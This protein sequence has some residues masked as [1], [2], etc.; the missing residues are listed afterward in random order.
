MSYSTVFDGVFRRVLCHHIPPTRAET[1]TMLPITM[2]MVRPL[3]DLDL[4][5]GGGAAACVTVVVLVVSSVHGEKRVR[6]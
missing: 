6:E 1:P 3:F 2:P 4:D 5:G